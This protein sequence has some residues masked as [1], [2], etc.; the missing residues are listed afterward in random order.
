MCGGISLPDLFL[1]K[2]YVA[3][4]GNK[5]VYV[6]GFYGIGFNYIFSFFL[7]GQFGNKRGEELNF[8]RIP[9][10][11]ASLRICNRIGAAEGRSPGP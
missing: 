11:A 10:A 9:A 4:V 3:W 8:C 6:N 2:A 5:G 7:S 1:L